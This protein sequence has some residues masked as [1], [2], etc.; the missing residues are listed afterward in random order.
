[1]ASKP[2]LAGYRIIDFT[3]YLAG[4]SAT[5]LMAEMG[6]DIIKVEMAP[7]G[8][9]SRAFPYRKNKRSAYYVQQNRGKK[10]LCVDLKDARSKQVIRDLIRQCDVLIEN[11]APGVI[12]RLG[13]GWEVVR[14]LNPKLVMCSISAFGQTGPLSHLSGFDYIAQ[15]YAGVTSVIGEP[16]RPPSL[17]ML[18]IGDVTTGVHAACALGFALLDVHRTGVGQHL[19]I[20]LLDCYFHHHEMNVQ[21]YS[22]S[23]GAMVPRRA[24]AHHYAVAPTGIFRGPE[25]YIM[26]LALL[27]QWPVLCKAMGREDLIKDARFKTNELRVANQK[28]LIALIEGWLQSFPS[29]AAAI[30]ALQAVRVPVAPILTVAQAVAHPHH[31]A[32]GTVR[33][34]SDRMLGEFDIPGMPLRFSNH[35]EL[36]PLQA[37]LLGEH[38]AEILTGLLGYGAAQV[39]ELEQG[40]VLVSAAH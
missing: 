20:S 24:G 6:A 17:P 10:S 31:R 23:G 40:G 11:Y 5:R 3:Q 22:A 14:E 25:G 39:A 32:R 4:P 37:P 36:P 13:F 28:A 8:D 16:D 33:T 26:I 34:V 15:A 9:P 38:N 30:A 19:D 18:A 12:A 2:I 29:D 7:F 1:M 21:A 35:P 27:H